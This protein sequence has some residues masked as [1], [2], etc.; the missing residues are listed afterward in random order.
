MIGKTLGRYEI[1]GKLGEGGMASV[2]WARDP[3]LNRQVAVK[4]L[5]PWC[6]NDPGH[7]GRFKR[8][9]RLLADL[10]HPNIVS[11]FDFG[12][13]E[14]YVF[15][16]M[17]FLSGGSLADE[18]GR[19]G[20][21]DYKTTLRLAS[22]IAGALDCIHRLGICHRDLKPHNILKSETGQHKLADFGL[23]KG[24]EFE[25]ITR[26][27]ELIGTLRYLPPE[28]LEG[29][30]LD[31]TA[32]LFQ[33][34]LVLYEAATGARPYRGS[35]AV[36][37]IRS[38]SKDTPPNPSACCAD[39]PQA[40][41]NFVWNL[42]QMK[43]KDRYTDIQAVL[44]DLSR[45]ERGGNVRRRQQ[46]IRPAAPNTAKLAAVKASSP[47][48]IPPPPP[49]HGLPPR[50]LAA[51]G[52]LFL[53]VLLLLRP[54]TFRSTPSAPDVPTDVSVNVGEHTALVSWK[55][56]LPSRG[57]VEY[58][59]K[60]SEVL[61]VAE[62]PSPTTT[63]AVSITDLEPGKEY[64]L[65]LRGPGGAKAMQRTVTP[66]PFTVELVRAEAEGGQG[67]IEWRSSQP[68]RSKLLVRAAEATDP[69]VNVD[70]D[71]S[72]SHVLRFEG[73]PPGVGFTLSV[74][75]FNSVDEHKRLDV[76][77]LVD[78]SVGALLP[79]PR[80]E[81]LGAMNAKALKWL[82]DPSRSMLVAARSILENHEWR[83]MLITKLPT[84]GFFLGNPQYPLEA[85]A[86]IY[87]S[88]RLFQAL[89][90]QS[91]HLEAL[92]AT[93]LTSALPVS[94]MQTDTAALRQGEVLKLNVNA[95]E[96]L[97]A[98]PAYVPLSKTGPP[99]LLAK[100]LSVQVPSTIARWSA[101]ELRLSGRVQQGTLIDV[102]VNG[103][104]SLVILPS[105]TE[106]TGE[107]R[108]VQRIP[109]E[110]ISSNENRITLTLRPMP[111]NPKTRS[112]SAVFTSAELA[113]ER[114]PEKDQ[115]IKVTS[116]RGGSGSRR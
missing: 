99:V 43:R 25:T 48:R 79:P 19:R 39:V 26:A 76:L 92:V 27:G 75:A 14:E 111:G 87:R 104:A 73:F 13:V 67:L 7:L 107:S 108:L 115:P 23:G 71:A 5:P 101:A 91:P 89:E 36:E 93:G 58:A 33:L 44:G 116:Q 81:Q 57:V 63:H 53:M 110:L 51:M 84:L 49:K 85:R 50:V 109:V 2:Y 105:S 78:T 24:E 3:K 94:W 102:D 10:S 59:P 88:I 52:L 100:V 42:V 20:R 77:A 103:R 41:D 40:F 4:I 31:H 1:L 68:T 6:K 8:E 18:I 61:M 90:G 30:P 12:E 70:E 22:E 16:A 60:S 21:M 82:N 54:G 96:T 29:E 64:T 98:D 113:L 56:R 37:I 114:G 11:I 35:N 65:S 97:V 69:D 32:D 86:K 9:V 83:R 15:Y 80:D 74:D 106:A 28:G 112:L 55:T 46:T 38:Y 17:E 95:N 34:G 45:L 62:E 66:Q 72:T 47:V